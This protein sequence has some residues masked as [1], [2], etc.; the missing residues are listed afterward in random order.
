M[1]I[2]LLIKNERNKI[3][4]N[5]LKIAFRSLVRSKV[6]SAIHFLQSALTIIAITLITVGFQSIRAALINPVNSLKRE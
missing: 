1:V 2:V 5:Y 6:Y 3:L 4:N